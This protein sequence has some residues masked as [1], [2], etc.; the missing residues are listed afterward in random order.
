MDT[1]T[2]TLSITIHK[3]QSI[4]FRILDLNTSLIDLNTSLINTGDTL[5]LDIEPLIRL[6]KNTITKWL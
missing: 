3:F 4:L 5:Q 1:I 6:H 2:S